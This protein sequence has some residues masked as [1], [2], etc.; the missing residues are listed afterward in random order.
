MLSVIPREDVGTRGN[1][2][3]RYLLMLLT[4]KSCTALVFSGEALFSRVSAIC[5]ADQAEGWAAG[6]AAL[7][8]HPAS[9]VGGHGQRA[10]GGAQ[11]HQAPVCHEGHGQAG[12]G[13]QEQ[14]EQG[15][16]RT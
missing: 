9:G 11:G 4:R 1:Q 7:P 16:T 15:R 5:G 2:R 8:A 13:Q 10:P 14:G 12:H 3:D 6:A